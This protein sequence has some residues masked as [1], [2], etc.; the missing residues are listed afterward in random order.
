MKLTIKNNKAQ[1]LSAYQEQQKKLEEMNQ[2]QRILF[3][4]VGLFFITNFI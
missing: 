1:I 2:E 4:L 3:A